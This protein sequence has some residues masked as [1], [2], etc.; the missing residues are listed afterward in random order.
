M[1][2]AMFLAVGPHDE[3]VAWAKKY[4]SAGF[5]SLWQAELTNSA[6]IRLAAIAPSVGSIK[7]GSGVVLAFNYRDKILDTFTD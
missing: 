1:K 3:M 5:D 6:L 2:H 4:E 7:I